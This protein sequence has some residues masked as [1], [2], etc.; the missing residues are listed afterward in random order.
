MSL[1]CEKKDCNKCKYSKDEFIVRLIGILGPVI[2][3]VKPSEILSFSKN[4]KDYEDKLNKIEEVFSKC[5][6]IK[7]MVIDY[8]GQGKKVLFY[9]EN[10]LNNTLLDKRNLK[11]LKSI[12]YPSSYTLENYL[13]FIANK[14][15][16]GTI[17]HEIGV[18]LGYPL[19]DVLG[20]LGYPSLK[21]TKINGW[22][23]YGDSL[24]SDIKY[25]EFKN[26]KESI[27]TLLAVSSVS[28]ILYL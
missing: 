5:T 14:I 20:F 27:K 26:A 4:D 21:L 28:E 12:G 9:R 13:S 2:L 11:F 15:G 23:V 8:N 7:Y 19:K 10:E 3:K 6:E 22:R 24:L 25:N 18:F 1:N 16:E 17:P